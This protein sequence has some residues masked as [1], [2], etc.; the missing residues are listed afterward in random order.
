MLRHFFSKSSYKPVSYSFKCQFS[1]EKEHPKTEGKQVFCQPMH[2]NMAK[3]LLTEN[4]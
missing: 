3:I 1:D 4:E 2:E